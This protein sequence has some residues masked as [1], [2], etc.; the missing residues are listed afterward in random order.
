MTQTNE[1]VAQTGQYRLANGLNIYYEE[2]GTGEPLILLHGGLGTGIG[3]WASQIPILSPH[4]RIVMPDARA[5]GNTQNPTE[6]FSLQLLAADVVALIGAL[7]LDKPTICG[8]SMGA[9]TALEIGLHYPDLAKA[10]VMGGVLYR[11]SNAYL[12]SLKALGVEGPGQ[13]NFEHTEKVNP[14]L[15][16]LVR[17]LHP[18]GPD[19]WKTLLTQISHEQ[20]RPLPYSADDYKKIGVPTLLLIGDRDQFIPVEETVELYRMIP[21]AELAVIPQADHAVARMK[22]ELFADIVLDFLLRHGGQAK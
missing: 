3:Q 18:Q 11:F 16:E 6:E 17:S 15:I 9:N 7:N 10:L 5:H 12:A 22:A 1:A 19:Y 21:N 4:F 13:V 20:Y 8:W 2:F 14:Q